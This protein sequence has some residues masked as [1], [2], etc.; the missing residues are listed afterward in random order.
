M[1][2]LNNAYCPVVERDRLPLDALRLIGTDDGRDVAMAVR[3][4][5]CNSCASMGIVCD[6]DRCGP[7]LV[8]AVAWAVET[9]PD[10]L[11]KGVGGA[12]R[13]IYHAYAV[14]RIK[15]AKPGNSRLRELAWE[16]IE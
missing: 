15:Q 3:N 10:N 1:R 5:L 12:S 4:C 6:P 9:V 8:K 16:L 11:P 2:Y 13:R 7:E 14:D